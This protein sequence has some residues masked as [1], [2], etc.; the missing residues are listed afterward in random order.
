MIEQKEILKKKHYT[1]YKIYI[2]IKL[3]IS[4]NIIIIK[5]LFKFLLKL[6]LLKHNKTLIEI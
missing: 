5:L 2:N 3:I 6:N 4:Y 1:K